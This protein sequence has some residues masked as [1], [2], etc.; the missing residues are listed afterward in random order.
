MTTSGTVAT[1]V[2]DTAK[3]L[4]HAFRRVKI[5]PA[6]QTPEKVALAQDNL[7]LLLTNLS[8]RGLNLWAVEKRYIGLTQGQATYSCPTGTID[9]LNLVYATPTRATGTDT[10]TATAIST[11]LTTATNIVRIG[12]KA[13]AVTAAD[14]LTLSS[15]DDG[16]TWST[17]SST[18]STTWATDTWYWFDV[19]PQVTAQ[20]F[21]A[22]FGLA[23]TFT[24]FYLAS[25]VNDLP[26][27]AWNRDTYSVINDKSKQG[28][29][30][31]TYF[32]EK[33]ISPQVTVWPVPDTSYNYLTMW[34]HRQ[35]QDVGTLTQTLEIP[36]R[37]YEA[38]IWE[39]AVRLAFEIQGVDP[40]IIQAVQVMADK[41]T[42]EAEQEES[43]GMPLY[44]APTIRGYTR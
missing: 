5:S 41:F 8:N 38:I 36:S 9:L 26:V 3:V 24:E 25:Q 37:W 42:N 16:V 20:Y 33:L 10:T 44:I 31:T 6:M 7:Y 28:H 43:D 13:S 34:I 35:V 11:D 29:P 23:A 14:T 19:S 2:L 32:F 40:S 21:K 18:T 12:V 30:S 1:T 27:T 39:L 15:S 4:E 17:L 22:A